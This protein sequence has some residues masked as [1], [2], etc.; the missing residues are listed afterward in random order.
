MQLFL[1]ACFIL[2]L[3][4]FAVGVSHFVHHRHGK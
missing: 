1:A 2:F 3:F 4:L